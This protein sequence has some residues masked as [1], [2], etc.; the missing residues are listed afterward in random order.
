[1]VRKVPPIWPPGG[2]NVPL[3][4]PNRRSKKPPCWPCSAAERYCGPQPLSPSAISSDWRCAARSVVPP[5]SCSS[6][7]CMRSSA[8]RCWS[9]C[10]LSPPHCGGGLLKI[11]KKPELSQPMRRDLRDQPV[12]FELLAVDRFF[13]AADLIGARRIVVAA[14]E[15]GELGFQPLA[16][17][18]WRLRERRGAGR[19][20]SPPPRHSKL[21]RAFPHDRHSNAK[22]MSCA[23]LVLSAAVLPSARR[24]H[25]HA[26]DDD[27]GAEQHEN[28]EPFAVKRPADHRDQRNAHEIERNHQRGIAGAEGVAQTIVRRQAGNADAECGQNVAR[29]EMEKHRRVAADQRERKLDHRHPEHDAECGLGHGQ[30]LGGDHGDGVAERRARA[31]ET[32][33][34]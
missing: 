30:L 12:D 22:I 8:L 34:D 17:R 14:V 29:V 3:L 32:P 33:P 26:G 18:I 11:E 28:V 25:K 10:R 20:A 2:E 13:G 31:R 27:Q 6:W 9:I 5:L 7:F 23:S 15:R 19:Q 24:F 4:P 1:M 21:A 16:G